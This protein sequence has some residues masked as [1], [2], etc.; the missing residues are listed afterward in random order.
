MGKNGRTDVIFSEDITEYHSTYMYR[1]EY[2]V[3]FLLSFGHMC[4]KYN[5]R[6]HGV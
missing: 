4:R 5:V 6:V 1:A 2:R 3:L